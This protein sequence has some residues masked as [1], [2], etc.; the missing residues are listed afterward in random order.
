MI[1]PSTT[2]SALAPLALVSL[3]ACGGCA[4]SNRIGGQGVAPPAYQ[5]GGK[6]QPVSPAPQGRLQVLVKFKAGVRA[7]QLTALRAAFG[8]RNVGMIAGIDVSVEEVI[9]VR[10]L[11][12]LL[13]DLNRS[14]LVEYAEANGSVSLEP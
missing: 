9:G 8:I 7:E 2:L 3:L 4:A 10:P 13:A 5:T 12:D 14:P 1:Q 11:A 6:L